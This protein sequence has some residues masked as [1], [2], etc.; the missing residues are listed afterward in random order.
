MYLGA[1]RLC[2]L[3]AN[4]SSFTSFLRS[5]DHASEGQILIN[6]MRSSCH[7]TTRH[8]PNAWCRILQIK[9]YSEPLHLSVCLSHL[10]IRGLFQNAAYSGQKWPN[11][12]YAS[13]YVF[14][15]DSQL[16]W[17]CPLN[18][19]SVPEFDLKLQTRYRLEIWIWMQGSIINKK[20]NWK[21]I[22][23]LIWQS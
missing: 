3:I 15:C 1:L 12:K 17:Q 18:S 23:Y 22:T 7:D 19:S 6:N 5:V 11:P 16:N 4:R 8:L 9:T 20:W 14:K 13:V 2:W 10:V 21:K